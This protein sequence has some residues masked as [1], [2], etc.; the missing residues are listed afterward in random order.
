MKK[1][2]KKSSHEI[3][4]RKKKEINVLIVGYEITNEKHKNK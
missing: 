3:V 2:K 1:L 4:N